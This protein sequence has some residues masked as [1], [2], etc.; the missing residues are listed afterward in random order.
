MYWD[1]ERMRV[2]SGVISNGFLTMIRLCVGV[3]NFEDL[4]EDLGVVVAEVI[5][6]FFFGVVGVAS[7]SVSLLG[8][9]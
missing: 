4:T 6:I 1:G 8:T 9:Y 7:S 5:F 2:P 3:M